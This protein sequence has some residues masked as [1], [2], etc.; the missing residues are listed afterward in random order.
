MSYGYLKNEKALNTW[1]V[2][3]LRRVWMTHPVKMACI[4]KKRFSLKCGNKYIYHAQCT[5]CKK[6]FKL[7][8]IEVNHKKQCGSSVGKENF[9]K[10][11]A[12]L[13]YITE[14]DVELVCKTCHQIITY[15]QIHSISFKE[16]YIQKRFIKFKK[17]KKQ[18]QIEKLLEYGL[19]DLPSKKSELEDIALNIIRKDVEERC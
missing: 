7:K 5:Q 14:D 2:N 18:E 3:Q 9:S 16:A 17:L 13:L 11:A 1:L 4:Q 8:D 12:S 19:K 15:S 6:S 10:F